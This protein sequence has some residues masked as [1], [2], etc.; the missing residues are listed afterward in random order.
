M[1]NAD[2]KAKRNA[3]K[4]VF[5][6]NDSDAILEGISS[7]CESLDVRV[8]TSQ[9]VV[10][11]VQL[12]RTLASKGTNVLAFVDLLLPMSLPDLKALR[13][14]SKDRETFMR[15]VFADRANL[16]QGQLEVSEA[17]LMGFD[18]SLINTEGGV[19]FLRESSAWTKEWRI[20]ILSAASGE[21]ILKSR[22]TGIEVWR[23]LSVPFP[24]DGIE[25]VIAEFLQ[26]A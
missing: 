21:R 19:E 8:V 1:A 9:C 7:V 25:A 26:G 14:V 5:V 17:L 20:V 12:A 11:A 24:A 6:L 16:K 22:E 4:V 10:E 23:V 15:G 13:K 3:G 2:M 18:S